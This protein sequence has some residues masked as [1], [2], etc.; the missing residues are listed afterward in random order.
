MNGDCRLSVILIGLGLNGRDGE[1]LRNFSFNSALTRMI[2]RENISADK[3]LSPPEIDPRASIDQVAT[4]LTDL[5]TE[6]LFS[7]TKFD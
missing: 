5:L 4:V 6:L 3:F 1:G 7:S 2:A